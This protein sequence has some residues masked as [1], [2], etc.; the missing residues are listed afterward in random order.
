MQAMMTQLGARPQ[1][2]TQAVLAKIEETGAGTGWFRTGYS[3]GSVP[4]G[5]YIPHLALVRRNF[6]GTPWMAGMPYDAPGYL[7]WLDASQ[8]ELNART[9]FQYLIRSQPS[10]TSSRRTDVLGVSSSTMAS[11]TQGLR[12]A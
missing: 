3:L 2:D 12:D 10:P 8:F 4:G 6:D 9:D 11:V 5:K 1:S 7:E